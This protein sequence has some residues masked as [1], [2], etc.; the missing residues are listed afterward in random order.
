MLQKTNK[1]YW[2]PKIEN[3][4]KRDRKNK[5]TIKSKG[6]NL[7]IIWEHEIKSDFRKVRNKI[8]ISFSMR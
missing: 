3:N 4:V 7:V 1:A 8:K 2:I 6:H 5:K